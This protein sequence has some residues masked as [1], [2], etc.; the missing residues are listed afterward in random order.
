ME[1]TSQ[2]TEGRYRKPA[3]PVRNLGDWRGLQIESMHGGQEME[4]RSCLRD[5]VLKGL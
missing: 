3:R 5:Q 4:V 2:T 1:R